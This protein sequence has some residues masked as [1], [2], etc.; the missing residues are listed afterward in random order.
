MT[1]D[2][3]NEYVNG[4]FVQDKRR[5][6]PSKADKLAFSA[7]YYLSWYFALYGKILN[8]SRTSIFAIL[9]ISY[10]AIKNGFSLNNTRALVAQ[11]RLETGDF[12]SPMCIKD[13]NLFGMHYPF[14]R[15][16]YAFAGRWNASELSDVSI[17]SSF[18][19]SILDRIEW[20]KQWT[21]TPIDV[22]APV[23]EYIFNVFYNYKAEATTYLE[24]WNRLYNQKPSIF[25]KV[26]YSIILSVVP[27][28]YYFSKK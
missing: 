23:Q 12:T 27:F 22:K 26:C 16:T 25:D 6:Y 15:N 14:S 8:V 3:L 17:Y 11:S 2:E 19:E 20:E 24:D 7:I 1:I 13:N 10:Y 21:E 28:V 18:L 9:C 4:D 5:L